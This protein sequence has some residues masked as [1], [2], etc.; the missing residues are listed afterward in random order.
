MQEQELRISELEKELQG[1]ASA[2]K[3]LE[4]QK[5]VLWSHLTFH[6]WTL[7]FQEYESSLLELRS[8]LD[9]KAS[10][11][12]VVSESLSWLIIASIL[13]WRNAGSAT[14]GIRGNAGSAWTG[15]RQP[16]NTVFNFFCGLGVSDEV[17]WITEI[18]RSAKRVRSWVGAASSAENS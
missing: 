13:G 2:E 18:A 1:K 11:V 15:I 12:G 8:S 4:E 16:F 5:Q 17:R 10:K 7:T 3:L 9:R 6:P 14:E